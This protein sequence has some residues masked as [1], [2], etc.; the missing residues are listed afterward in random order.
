MRVTIEKVI[1]NAY[2]LSHTKDG[3][4]LFVPYTVDGDIVECTVTDERKSF[5]YALQ[6]EVVTPSL[7]RVKPICPHYTI[8]GGCDM[9]HISREHELSIKNRWIEEDFSRFSAASSI[10][11]AIKIHTIFNKN[12]TSYRSRAKFSISSESR[13]FLKHS[14]NEVVNIDSCPL[15]TDGLNA[16]LQKIKPH[17]NLKD[18]EV[19]TTTVLEGSPLISVGSKTIEADNTVFFQQNRDIALAIAEYIQSKVQGKIVYDFYG[20]VGFFSSFLE[21]DYDVSCIESNK[22]AEKFAHRNL[23]KARFYSLPTEDAKKCLKKRSDTSIVDPPRSGMTVKAI[24]TVS[25]LTNARIIYISCD[26]KTALR[27]LKE[28]E[29]CGFRVIEVTPFDMFPRT[30][31][32]ETC[33]LLGRKIIED[34]NVEYEHVD[35]EPE[36]AEYMRG[37]KGSATYAEIKKW[38]KEQYNVSVSSLY[39]AQ[40]KDECGFEKRDNYN[41]GAEGHRVPQ[42]PDEKKKLIMEAFK[43]FRMI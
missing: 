25:S 18:G 31:H 30:A 43:H 29:K 22:S 2:G 34:K 20:G 6:D 8:C 3:K 16:I 13:G 36:D 32:L 35:Y 26:Y 21:D 27:D 15:L 7:F 39:I 9:L 11:K 33:V 5:A 17:K 37:A 40:C 38:I 12:D 4:A 41:K 42:C 14:S 19:D 28:F 24:K 1:N 23:K 10:S